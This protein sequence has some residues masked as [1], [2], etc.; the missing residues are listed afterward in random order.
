MMA[1]FIAVVSIIPFGSLRL[2]GF[3]THCGSLK[4]FGFLDVFGSLESFGFL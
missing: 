3:L 1:R 2:P 4:P